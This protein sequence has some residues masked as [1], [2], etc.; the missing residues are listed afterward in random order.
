MVM[1]MMIVMMVMVMIMIMIT[2]MIMIMIMIMT[3]MVMMM[4]RVDVKCTEIVDNA[5][6]TR[7][8]VMHMH[9][10]RKNAKKHISKEIQIVASIFAS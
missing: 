8:F 6:I 10:A 7:I 2:I 9:F 3:M 4:G 5:L 1:V